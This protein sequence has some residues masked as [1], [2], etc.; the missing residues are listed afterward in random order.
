MNPSLLIFLA[1]H[2][3]TEFNC[4]ERFCGQTDS[5]L[6]KVGIEE[7]HRNGRALGAHVGAHE[8][9]RIVSSPMA[10]AQE[11]ARIIRSE[12]GRSKQPIEIDARLREIAFGAWEGLTIPEIESRFDGSWAQR[13]HNKWTYAPPGGESY[14]TVAR[15]VG[16]WLCEAHGPTLVVTHGVVDR[17]M[18]GLYG[19]MSIHDICELPEPQ[20]IIFQLKGGQ[21]TAL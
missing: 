9:L 11:T 2:G 8:P 21:I 4:E 12:L 3:Q 7:A 13:L 6:T 5:P 1:R 19:G 14:A 10:R 15:R 20:N 18:R 17:I 16:S